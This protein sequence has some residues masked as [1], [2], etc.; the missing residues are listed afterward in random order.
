[1]SEPVNPLLPAPSTDIFSHALAKRLITTKW[2][3]AEFPKRVSN[4]AILAVSELLRLFVTEARHRAVI[5][6][7]CEK[8]GGDA[9]S[10]EISREGYTPIHAHHISKVAAELIMDFS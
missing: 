4:E 10:M 6:A 3:R 9:G 5:E 2:L 8:E 1:M 7:E